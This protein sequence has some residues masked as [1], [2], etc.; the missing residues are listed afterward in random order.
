VG[1]VPAV[2][3][4]AAEPPPDSPAAFIARLQHLMASMDTGRQLPD[5]VAQLEAC[6]LPQEVVQ[7][8][9]GLVAAGFD[10][11]DVVAGFIF[12]LAQSK[13]GECF[14][15]YVKRVILKAWKQVVP[16]RELDAGFEVAVGE[17]TPET[18]CWVR[19]AV[20]VLAIDAT[21]S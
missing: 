7:T 18:W 16:G 14:E 4:V 5:N 20:E 19:E 10:E 15:R 13:A 2:P 3:P 11:A 6:G 17:T 12:A 8:L 21:P 9:R 1:Q